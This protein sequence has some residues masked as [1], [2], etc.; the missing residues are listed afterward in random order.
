MGIT[1]LNVYA[2]LAGLYLLRDDHE[3]GLMDKGV[4]PGG[5][6]EVEL[7][8]QDRAFT[9][10]GQLS[11]PLD[12][13]NPPDGMQ[14]SI[15]PDF[16]CVNGMPWPYLDVEP[17][18][19][20]FRLLNATDSRFLILRLSNGAP[21]LRVGTD[22]GLSD[23]AVGLDRLFIAPAE[24]YDLVVDFSDYKG[25]SIVLENG[26][27]DGVLRGFG[28]ADGAIVT[29]DPLDTPWALNG[30]SA[31]NAARRTSKVMEFRVGTTRSRTPQATVVEGT[32]LRPGGASLPPVGEP[33]YTRKVVLLTGND[34]VTTTLGTQRSR[35][36]ELL[37]TMEG[38]TFGFMDPITE[39]P[40]LGSIEVWEIYNYTVPPRGLAHPIHIHLVHFQ[41][42]DREAFTVEGGV[43]ALVD[44]PMEAHEGIVSMTG[45][46]LPPDTV[47][48]SGSPR[49]PEPWEQGWKDTVVCYPNEV[50]RVIAKF[51]RP[52]KYVWHCHILHHEDHDMMR[53]F[54]VGDMPPMLA[55]ASTGAE[56]LVCHPE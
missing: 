43:G 45:K 7:V 22:L 13:Q 15:F 39:N 33:T 35:V 19:Y 23:E 11:M 8:V 42:V 54:F 5:K 1:R 31:P 41:V 50:T 46:F 12:A 55:R 24:R 53:P 34:V 4:L 51:D 30:P 25:Q 36:M 3:L 27:L 26:G 49:P 6:Y 47:T 29:N 10:D 44:K 48:L 18:K 28:T 14:V 20:R 21:I 32:Q 37:G 17:R 9:D 52:G 16:M 2:G 56:S 38:G 40:K